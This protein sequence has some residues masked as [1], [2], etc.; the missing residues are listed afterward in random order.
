VEVRV[1]E[2]Q[3]PS[4]Q[5]W[6]HLQAAHPLDR[7]GFA[8]RLLAVCDVLRYLLHVPMPS[9]IISRSVQVF[10]SHLQNTCVKLL[11]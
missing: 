11:L 9:Y 3:F 2:L 5:A 6:C 8:S 4:R 7:R 10:F 1:W